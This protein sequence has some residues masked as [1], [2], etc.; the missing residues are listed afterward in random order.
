MDALTNDELH[1]QA[2]AVIREI[3]NRL[4]GQRLRRW[5][6]IHALIRDFEEDIHSDGGIS[7]LSVGGGKDV[8]PA[9]AP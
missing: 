8:P 5:R 2:V 7:A 9:P 3:E 4:T 6:R 1:G